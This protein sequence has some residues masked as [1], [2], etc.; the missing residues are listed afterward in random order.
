VASVCA[1]VLLCLTAFYPGRC[2]VFYYFA[3]DVPATLGGEDRPPN[4]ILLGSNGA[5]S[6]AE[7]LPPDVQVGAL[8]RR[9]TGEWLFAPADPADLGGQFYEPRDI[10]MLKGTTFTMY[11]SGSSA[12]IPERA[13]VDALFFDPID[14][15]PVMSFDVPVFLGP[16]QYTRSDLVK[17][18]PGVGF[19]L[20]WDAEAAGVP[21]SSNV[22]GADIDHTGE[23]VVTF[24]VPTSLGG[25]FYLPG[26]LVGWTSASFSLY[27]SDPTWPLSAQ[28]RDFSLVPIAP[29]SGDADPTNLSVQLGTDGNL[30]LTWGASCDAGDNDYEVYEGALAGG[31]FVYDHAIR[32]CTTGGLTSVTF[33]PSLGSTYYLIVPRNVGSEG[34]YGQTSAGTERPTAAHACLPQAVSCT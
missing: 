27:F 20:Y 2:D 32:S 31:P 13:R 25:V 4:Q 26:Q 34:S 16:A 18:T 11:L 3:T 1:G 22:V 24:D 5:Y 8:D 6:L 12:G 9:P 14:G 15:N 30:T 29:P 28:L 10:V 33:T 7:L 19:S 17:F 23:L 21:L